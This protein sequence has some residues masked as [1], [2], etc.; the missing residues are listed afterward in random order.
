MGDFVAAL[1][2]ISLTLRESAAAIGGELGNEP[3]ARALKRA[4]SGLSS[5]EIMPGAPA[6]APRTLGELGL[7]TNRDGTFSFDQ[8]RLDRAHERDAPAVSAMFTTGAFGVFPTVD[9]LARGMALASD[10]GPLA[11]AITRYTQHT[12]I[13][14]AHV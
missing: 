1:N 4:L 10:P 11:G 13:G 12:K 2:D 5:L 9:D 8:T 6:D 14:R 3:G 7:A